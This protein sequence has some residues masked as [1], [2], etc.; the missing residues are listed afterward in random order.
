MKK[1]VS[2]ILEAF[3]RTNSELGRTYFRILSDGTLVCRVKLCNCV[4]V[5]LQSTFSSASPFQC[6]NFERCQANSWWHMQRKSECPAHC[7]GIAV[8]DSMTQISASL[9]T[10][11]K[12]GGNTH[13][14][15]YEIPLRF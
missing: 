3:D 14:L 7:L 6:L 1:I 8:T 13:T 5:F 11:F 10:S 4:V 9:L 2:V 15:L 12:K